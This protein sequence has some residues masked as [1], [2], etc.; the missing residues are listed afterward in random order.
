M[1]IGMEEEDNK[2]VVVRTKMEVKYGGKEDERG[3]M[4]PN[5]VS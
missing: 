4:T 5:V 3:G 2:S 1:A